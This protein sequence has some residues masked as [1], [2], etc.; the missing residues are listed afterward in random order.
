MMLVRFLPMILSCLLMAAHVLRSVGLT[1]ALLVLLLPLLL[2]VRQSWVPLVMQGVLG[3]AVLEWAR[4]AV[5]LARGRIAEGEPWMRMAVILG[6]VAAVTAAA[7][8][9][10]RQPAVRRYFEPSANLP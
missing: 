2:L 3:L 6:A 7:M 1:A 5:V 9:I 10:F 8:L 4:T